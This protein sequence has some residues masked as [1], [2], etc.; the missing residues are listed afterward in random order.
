MDKLQV[1]ICLFRKEIRKEKLSQ[2]PEE[3]VWGEI[4]AKTNSKE[5]EQL[6]KKTEQRV[7]F[8]YN[9]V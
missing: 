1:K 7:N 6:R 2:T 5:Q 4:V 8:Q 3:T 9:R